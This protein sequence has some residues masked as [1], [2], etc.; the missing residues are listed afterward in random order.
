MTH[1]VIVKKLAEILEPLKR[2]EY[3]GVHI[4]LLDKKSLDEVLLL[5]AGVRGGVIEKETGEK[6][7]TIDPF[8][9]FAKI[10]NPKYSAFKYS[11]YL[12]HKHKEIF[13]R[14]KIKKAIPKEM[15]R[16]QNRERKYLRERIAEIDPPISQE[17]ADKMR[18]EL[19]DQISIDR[20][21]VEKLMD[22]FEEYDVAMTSFEEKKYYPSIYFTLDISAELEGISEEEIKK[23]GLKPYKKK[24][25]HLRKDVPNLLWYK[26]ERPFSELRAN[27]K[28]SRIIKTYIRCCGSIYIKKKED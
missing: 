7:K 20:K 8:Y 10:L 6:S 3:E 17:V 26:D 1:E 5:E 11:F 25:T 4:Y 28:I 23:K 19:E 9:P 2:E 16:W 15:E 12:A 24:D 22:N 14:S 18:K 21:T 27:D 13:D